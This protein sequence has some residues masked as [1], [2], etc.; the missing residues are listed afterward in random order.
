LQPIIEVQRCVEN[1][2]V[3]D[4]RHYFISTSAAALDVDAM[5]P[6]ESLKHLVEAK[7]RLIEI[8]GELSDNRSNMLSDVLNDRVKISSLLKFRRALTVTQD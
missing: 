7:D 1:D 3:L 4:V 8:E 6:M 5:K 2:S